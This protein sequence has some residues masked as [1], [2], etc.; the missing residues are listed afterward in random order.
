MSSMIEE[1]WLGNLC[2]E[3]HARID[4]PEMKELLSLIRDNRERLCE[5]LTEAQKERLERYDDC[6]DEL[7]SITERDAFVLGFRLGMR[8]AAEAFFGL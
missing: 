1:L 2:P 4:T 8:L 3:E 6:T 7:A 5:G